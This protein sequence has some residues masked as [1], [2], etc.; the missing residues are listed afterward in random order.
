MSNILT[1][2]GD[3]LPRVLSVEGNF[4]S[5]IYRRLNVAL[6][7]ETSERC[8]W[9]RIR[10]LILMYSKPSPI[11]FDRKPESFDGFRMVW[12]PAIPIIQ[13]RSRPFSL[14]MTTESKALV[15]LQ[16][17]GFK[18]WADYLNPVLLYLLAFSQLDKG[19]RI[20]AAL[21]GIRW[22]TTCVHIKAQTIQPLN[23]FDLGFHPNRMERKAIYV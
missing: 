1:E 7:L 15:N 8:G 20:K 21:N 19:A 10:L 11:S 6:S 23:T 22:F 17:K 9:K 16:I 2:R 18:N 12:S 5:F 14:R 3:Y 4:L 13:I